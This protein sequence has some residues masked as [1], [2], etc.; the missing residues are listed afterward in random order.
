MWAIIS[1]KFNSFLF[2]SFCL[3][4]Y[5]FFFFQVISHFW[6]YFRDYSMRF[7]Y[8]TFLLQCLWIKVRKI[9]YFMNR[10]ISNWAKDRE[11]D[12]KGL[13]NVILFFIWRVTGNSL[14]ITCEICTQ[15]KS[16]TAITYLNDFFSIWAL[17]L[18]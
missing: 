15:S 14:E 3:T 12:D 17:S 10:G 11:K 7:L 13:E 4:E 6:K 5:F 16:I 9:F 18:S 8:F 1:E 2:L